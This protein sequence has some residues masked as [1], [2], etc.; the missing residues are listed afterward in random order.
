M[1]M[2]RNRLKDIRFFE[3]YFPIVF[4]MDKMKREGVPLKIGVIF[5][6]HLVFGVV[7]VAFYGV[8]EVFAGNRFDY[9]LEND[10]GMGSIGAT[11]TLPLQ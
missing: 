4:V 6:N 1:Q 11:E 10:C 2:R 5:F 7:I 3:A 8:F 9:F